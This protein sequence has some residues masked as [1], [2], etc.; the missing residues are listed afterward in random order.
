MIYK[1]T[2]TI[3]GDFYVGYTSLTL[4]DRFAKHKSNAK[5]GGET[6]LYRAIRKYGE[7]NFIIECLQEDGNLNEDES[8]WI[9]KLNPVYN[10]TK[11]G[12]GGNTSASPNYKAGMK[13]RRSYAKEGNPQYGKIGLN[14]P[15]SQKVLL[16]GKEYCSITEA[17]RLAHRSFAYV[18]KNGIFI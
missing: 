11:G 15:K 5:A 14:N 9:G 1:I 2:N 12:E 8:L 7:D 6:Y 16:D 3:T 18:K 13:N 10:M 17:R 4:E